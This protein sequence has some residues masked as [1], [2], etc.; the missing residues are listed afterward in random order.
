M[1]GGTTAPAPAQPRAEPRGAA[2]DARRCPRVVTI[3]GPTAVGKTGVA[4][5]VAARLGGEIVSADSRQI[6]RGMDIGTAKPTADE[7]RAV[8]HHLIDI[9]DPSER[10]DA[11]RFAADAESVIT[12][13]RASGIQPVVVGGTGFYLA[14]LFEGLFECPEKDESVRAEMA[15]RLAR[16]GVP[17][18]REELAR[19]DPESA[20]RIHPNDAAR[21]VRALE[22]HVLTGRTL[23]EW[24]A[25]ARREAVYAPRYFGLSVPR[26]SLHQRIERRVDQMMAAGL[27]QEVD[28][29]R[30]SGRLL[31][32]MPGASAVG[33]R[34]LLALGSH[35]PGAVA[36]A[37]RSIKT[38]TRRYAKRQMTWFRAIEGIE[39]LD[40]EALGT[41]GAAA[42]I[43]RRAA[44]EAGRSEPQPETP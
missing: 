31:P 7:Q 13:L 11:A 15:A 30:T 25:G 19:V 35:D 10:Y 26:R 12:V 37:V 8:G 44:A 34:E 5:L 14:S 17:A 42:E 20:A 3:V 1:S 40:V 41:E 23:T 27:L 24:H 18:L 28:A 2:R 22:V 36:A 21:I 32:G 16:D 9:V 38:S 43:V 33:Y 29:L 39:W 4:L 6:Y